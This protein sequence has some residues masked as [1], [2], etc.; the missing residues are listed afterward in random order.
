MD[1]R[2]PRRPGDAD[3]E[4]AIDGPDDEDA[5]TVGA[6]VAAALAVGLGPLEV[7][8]AAA[9]TWTAH[10]GQNS[11]RHIERPPR[12]SWCDRLPRGSVVVGG[13]SEGDRV[14]DPL[15]SDRPNTI[16]VPPL[17]RPNNHWL[18][19]DHGRAADAGLARAADEQLSAGGKTS[20]RLAVTL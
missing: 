10:T 18:S 20:D 15:P 5:V 19:G 13:L 9:T 6:G 17:S 16:E 8:Q 3:G 2:E 1:I 4:V 12:R 14:G 11:R 7:E